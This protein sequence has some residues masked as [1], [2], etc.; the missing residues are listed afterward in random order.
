MKHSMNELYKTNNNRLFSIKNIDN[1]KYKVSS[2]TC[3]YKVNDGSFKYLDENNQIKT[4]WQYGEKTWFDTKEERDSYRAESNKA[5][6]ELVAKNKVIKAINEK[7]N[8]KNL[9]ELL[10]I[11]SQM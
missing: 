7:L 9:T 10:D 5:Y 2:K 11:L 6:D 8:E 4:A 3:D 1:Q